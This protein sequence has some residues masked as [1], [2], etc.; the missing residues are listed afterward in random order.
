MGMGAWVHA[1]GGRPGRKAAAPSPGGKEG[2]GG[3]GHGPGPSRPAGKAGP[4]EQPRR[5]K[6][7][8]LGPSAGGQPDPMK[9]SVGYIGADSF[10]RIRQGPGKRGGGGRWC[11]GRP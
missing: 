7:R 10:N 6:S 5:E 9:T 3:H 4:A 1:V 8:R 2:W 11:R